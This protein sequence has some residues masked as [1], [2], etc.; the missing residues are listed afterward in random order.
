MCLDIFKATDGQTEKNCFSSKGQCKIKCCQDFRYSSQLCADNPTYIIICLILVYILH[1]NA[2]PQQVKR[3]DEILH[4]KISHLEYMYEGF[5][6]SITSCL[7][8]KGRNYIA[9]SNQP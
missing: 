4:F 5:K 9:C 3:C 1:P 2:I 7:S 8:I 6:V